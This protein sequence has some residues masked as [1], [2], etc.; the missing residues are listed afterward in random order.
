M[1][2][3][4]A[5]GVATAESATTAGSWYLL[6]RVNY[7]HMVDFALFVDHL[8][9]VFV[10][11]KDQASIFRIVVVNQIERRVVVELAREGTTSEIKFH[12]HI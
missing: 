1:D 10:Y 12:W 6:A 11:L 7:F 5:L 8:D 4:V 2:K 9:R 3:C